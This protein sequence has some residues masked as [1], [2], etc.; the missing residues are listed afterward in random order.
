M[1]TLFSGSKQFNTG[2]SNLPN[3]RNAKQA[4]YNEMNKRV[5]FYRA[6]RNWVFNNNLLVKILK[7]DNTPLYANAD[8]TLE[9]ARDRWL[10]DASVFGLNT[11][12]R[13]ASYLPD[14]IAYPAT[15]KEFVALDDS[16]PYGNEVKIKWKLLEPIRVLD[17]PFADLDLFIPNGHFKGN[18]KGSTSV[19]LSINLPLLVLQYRLWQK[20]EAVQDGINP[21]DAAVFL[22]RYPLTNIM[23]SHMDIVIRNR[24]VDFYNGV[25]PKAFDSSRQGGVVVNNVA[26]FVDAA[27]RHCVKIVSSTDLTFAALNQQVPQVSYDNVAQSLI[28]PDMTYTRPLRWVYD[29]SR[30]NWYSFLVQYNN[31]RGLHKNIQE[32]DYIRKRLGF[33]E[34]DKEFQTAVGLD[35]TSYYGKLRKLVG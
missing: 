27:L 35:A 8:H 9:A 5:S 21:D 10:N 2:V 30:V 17:H 26:N 33:M 24:F 31:D 22:M 13:K 28:L 29:A 16:L 19:F 3:W 18:A 20:Y 34:N 14:N 11:P 1:H 6:S 4:I 12:Y 7:S 23:N 32:I 25:E 15:V